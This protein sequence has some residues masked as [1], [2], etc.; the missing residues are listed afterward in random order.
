MNDDGLISVTDLLSL[1]FMLLAQYL[2]VIVVHYLCP[3]LAQSSLSTTSAWI[4]PK[5]LLPTQSR[6]QPEQIN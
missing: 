3:L 6:H 2:K 1:E 5:R 4:S